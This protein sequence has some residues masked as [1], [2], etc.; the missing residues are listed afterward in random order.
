MDDVSGWANS[1]LQLFFNMAYF[2]SHTGAHGVIQNPKK[3]VW[4]VRELEFLGFWIK[5]DG[6]RPT[7]ETLNAIKNF[8]RPTDVT[9]IRSWY[10]LVEQVAFS[11]TKTDL[12]QPFHQLLSKNA[13]FSWSPQLQTAFDTARQ[14]IVKLVTNGVQSFQLDTWTCIITDWSKSGVGYVMWQKRCSCHTIHPTCCKSG[15]AL[16]SCGSRFCTSAEQN[17][18][19]IEGELLAVTWALKKTAYYTLGLEKLLLL[20]DH[21]PLL[22]LLKSQNIGEIDNPRL[23]HLAERL[24]KWKF[25][26]QH[27]AGAQ[28]FAPDALSRYPASPSPEGQSIKVS[29]EFSSERVKDQPDRVVH[30][31]SLNSVPEPDQILS[32]KLE[33]Q[34]LATS[35]TRRVLVTSWEDVKLAAISDELYAQLLNALH[36]NRDDWPDTL[37]EY[38]RF[39]NDMTS[40]DGVVL[41]KG[42][43][44]IP[45][46]LR[47]Q[48][49]Q[50]LHSAH[51]GETSM[52]LR[53][54]E[55]VWWPNMSADIKDT[56]ARCMTC[57]QNSP[58]QLPLPPVHPP[59]PSY[60]FQ[61]ISS[62]YFTH[63]G[64]S[65]LVVV[66]RYSNWPIVR[67]CRTESAEELVTSLR[68]FFCDYGV[69]ETLTTD[70]GPAY[71]ST[72][73][74]DFLKNWGVTHRLTSA[75]NPHANLRSETAV[76]SM[77]RLISSNT[78]PGGTLKTDA[79]AAAL[80]VYRNT[81]DRDTRRSPSQILYARQLRDTLPC[82]P[83]KL[84]LRP[85]WVLTSE[86][87]K[88]AL[89]HRHLSIHTELLNKS[90]P[91]KPLE[92]GATVQVQN[93]RGPNANKWHLSGTIVEVQEFDSYLVKMDGTGRVTKRNRRY[94][95]PILPFHKITA[96]KLPLQNYDDEIQRADSDFINAAKDNPIDDYTSSYTG[97]TADSREASSSLGPRQQTHGYP[98]A[99]KAKSTSVQLSE[100]DS[101]DTLINMSDESF[102]K[103]LKQSVR[104]VQNAVKS[105][106]LSKQPEAGKSAHSTG[107]QGKRVKFQ[108]KR[109]IQQY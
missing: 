30:L 88:K 76:K 73:T 78:G 10:G 14:E 12:M 94:L 102:D 84:K 56:R 24:L 36:S 65:Y 104:N 92:L 83:D 37:A 80:L 39:R 87:R 95:K 46:V 40:V 18:H 61:M 47:P 70:G 67:R 57:T 23:L 4:G 108:T 48:T 85:E 22:G 35:A 29:D 15:W 45:A 34:I 42:R 106:V 3:F 8:P 50:A 16:I 74:Q 49:L 107:V 53:T 25:Q 33:A 62:D 105:T 58:T 60:P 77:K 21:K 90:R 27:I 20:V 64:H 100:P 26:I 38:K 31:N 82:T 101:A 17:Y 19:P 66:D 96:D 51:Q 97:P 72:I 5:Q 7:S 109:Y 28:N 44:V 79:L 32:D 99:A 41:F 9:G 98:A 13:E 69:P 89:A 81:P 86:L 6:V 93:Q 71:I 103:G 68:E 52:L 63:Q 11:F 91:L 55:A 54:N 75:Y 59:L 43:I 1:L 2:L